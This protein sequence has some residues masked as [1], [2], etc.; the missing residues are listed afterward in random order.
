M[1]HEQVLS[2]DFLNLIT[3]AKHAINNY[4]QHL[5][6]PEADRDFWNEQL[7]AANRSISLAW[8]LRWQALTDRGASA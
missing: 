2:D 4:E 8:E 1:N 5:A 6:N 7:E 3:C